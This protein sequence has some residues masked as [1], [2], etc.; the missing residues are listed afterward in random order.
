MAEI[1]IQK[2]FI[3][4]GFGFPVV[5]RNVPMIKVRGSWTP[6]VDYNKLA[7]DVLIALAHKPARLTGSEVR[8]IRQYFEMTLAEFGNRFSVSHPAVIK[9][10]GQD[11]ATSMKWPIEK[12]IRLFVLDSLNVDAEDLANLYRNLKKEAK[13]KGKPVEMKI[14]QAA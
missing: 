13:N 10:E 7:E 6:K 4:D 5:L 14:S 8:F 9:W 3:Y 11:E 2:R 12:D 1:K